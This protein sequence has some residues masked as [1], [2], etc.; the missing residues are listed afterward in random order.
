[1]KKIVCLLTLFICSSKLIPSLG[2][3]ADYVYYFDKD[4]NSTSASNAK[5]LGT[6]IKENGKIKLTLYDNETGRT[7]LRAFFSDSTLSVKNGLFTS[8]DAA[9]LEESEGEY[10]NNLKE[11]Y[12]L[13][14]YAELK[15]S[16][17]YV[18]GEEINRVTVYYHPNGNLATRGF[19]DIKN[20]RS[21]KLSWDS[22]GLL[23]SREL[24]D[25]GSTELQLL[26]PTGKIKQVE[27]RIAGKSPVNTYFDE[28][29]NDITKKIAAEQKQRDKNLAD[30]LLTTEPR[31][32]GGM[33][34]AYDFIKRNLRLPPGYWGTPGSS[35]TLQISF[36]LDKSGNAKDIVVKG[37]GRD[38]EAE[39]ASVLRRMPRWKMNG[40]T[41]YGPVNLSLNVNTIY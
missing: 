25:K 40:H 14:W 2:Q 17:Y 37:A 29:G 22:T 41:S 18:R 24:G 21:E 32:P 11:G 4:M 10:R 8:Y 31:F 28:N 13:H 36:M 6:G 15:D 5:V 19:Y 12:W 33:V 20:T 23:L 30:S 39:V 38:V 34:A 16:S 27:R 26:Y 1:M 7:L 3:S 35:S 9:G